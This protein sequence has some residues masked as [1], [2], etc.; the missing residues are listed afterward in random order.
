[1]AQKQTFTDGAGMEWEIVKTRTR[2]DGHTI[3]VEEHHQRNAGEPHNV[4]RITTVDH[5]VV[6][7]KGTVE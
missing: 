2:K 6:S 5:E 1:M 7:R 3:K 4:Y